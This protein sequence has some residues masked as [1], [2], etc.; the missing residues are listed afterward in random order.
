MVQRLLCLEPLQQKFDA[1]EDLQQTRRIQNLHNN[2]ASRASLA[3]A[4]AGTRIWP[5]LILV[6]LTP[7]GHTCLIWTLASDRPPKSA[8]STSPLHSATNDIAQVALQIAK[9]RLGI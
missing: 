9:A 1:S 8:V 5:H 6:E 4:S 7:H 3:E 2:L